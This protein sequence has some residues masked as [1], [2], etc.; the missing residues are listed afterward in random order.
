MKCKQYGTR[1]GLVGEY[2][3]FGIWWTW[4]SLQNCVCIEF[5]NN[6]QG[7]TVQ[8]IT[9]D[10]L[11]GMCGEKKIN[12]DMKLGNLLRIQR[13]THHICQIDANGAVLT[14]FNHQAIR[15]FD[16]N[17]HL[18]VEKYKMIASHQ[19]QIFVQTTNKL[20]FNL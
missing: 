3:N 2:I 4:T 10:P 19:I 5:T 1:F 11:T 9:Q 17:F 15:V 12:N 18:L 20:N 7:D 16:Y 6:E 14:T 8:D 13:H